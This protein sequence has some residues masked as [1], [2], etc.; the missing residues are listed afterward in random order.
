MLGQFAGAAA[1]MRRVAPAGMSWTA[2]VAAST[3]PLVPDDVHVSATGINERHP[4]CVDLGLAF[5]IVT[6]VVRDRSLG[7]DDQA[8]ARVRV[9]AGTS[10]RLPDV[11]LHVQV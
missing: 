4:L 5:G 8:M 1:S 11:A 7:D 3:V 9:P 6:F 2:M 10:S